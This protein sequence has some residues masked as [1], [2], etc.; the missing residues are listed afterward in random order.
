MKTQIRKT[1][2]QRTSFTQEDK[3]EALSLWRASGR[4]A[5]KVAAELGIRPPLLY[6]RAHTE[7]APDDP[8]GGRR[9][10]AASRSWR[11]RTI[12]YARRTP[13]SWSSVKCY[14]NRW[15]SSP[16]R[17][18]EVCPDPNRERPV[19]GSLVMRAL[20]VSRSG[21]SQWKKRRAEPGLP[22]VESRFLR[23]RHPFLYPASLRRDA[24][25]LRQPRISLA[26]AQPRS[27]RRRKPPKAG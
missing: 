16:K 23:G 17:R 20:L 12:V 7:R 8:R 25:H 4:G 24:P 10:R 11:Q 3:Q 2:R 21:Y 18:P 5:A 13:S 15:T 6:H 1:A 19:Q 9:P 14:K 22:Q 27:G 26:A